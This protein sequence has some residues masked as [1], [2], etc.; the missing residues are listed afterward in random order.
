MSDWIPLHIAIPFPNS[1]PGIIVLFANNTTPTSALRG[2]LVAL[3]LQ[4]QDRASAISHPHQ[5][6]A[7]PVPVPSDENAL[8]TLETPHDDR[9]AGN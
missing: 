3:G 5:P 2:S 7:Q 8:P 1:K 9:Q 6:Y 4:M